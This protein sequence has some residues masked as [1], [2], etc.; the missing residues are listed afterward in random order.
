MGWRIPQALKERSKL[1]SENTAVDLFRINGISSTE[2]KLT[3]SEVLYYEGDSANRIYIVR[4]GLCFTFR[5]HEDGRRQIVDL[6]F[7][8]DLVGLEALTQDYY[9]SGF[10]ALT[11]SELVAYPVDEFT[12]QCYIVPELS[13]ILVEYISREQAILTRRLVEVAHSSA[14]QRIA[15]FLLELRAR[16]LVAGMQALALKQTSPGREDSEQDFCIRI[17]HAVIADTLGLSIVH[18][19][20]TLSK[21]REQGLIADM[22]D[23]MAI[24][25]LPGLQKVADWEGLSPWF[26][27]VEGRETPA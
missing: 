3:K 2:L 16:A 4:R 12:S 20:R 21:L 25:D 15:H 24:V 13:R 14:S 11:A 19:S 1:S 7:P 22:E 8:G 18:V 17:P 10:T 23:G 26:D 9:V 5:H 27:K 6:S